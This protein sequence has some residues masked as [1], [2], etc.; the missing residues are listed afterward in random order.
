MGFVRTAARGVAVIAALSAA[1]MSGAA[2]ASSSD[3]PSTEIVCGLDETEFGGP[4]WY[5]TTGW[6]GNCGVTSDMLI[7]W[8]AYAAGS[9]VARGYACVPRNSHRYLG[10]ASSQQAQP[11]FWIS[12]YS[13]VY[14]S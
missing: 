11:H 8:E 9:V 3:A 14:C 5:T 4:G 6:Y 13:Y 10:A 12:S 2:H 1:L 7:G